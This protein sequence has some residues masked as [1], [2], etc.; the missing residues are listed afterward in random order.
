MKRHNSSGG[1]ALAAL[2]AGLLVMAVARARRRV[3]LKGRV[4]VVTGGGRG[5]GAAI[6]RELVSRGCRVAICGRDE[7]VI[8][9]AV[10]AL[11][12]EGADVMGVRCDVSDPTAT[13]AFVQS[14]IEEYGTVD[15]LVNNAGQCFV[16]PAVEL[17]PADLHRAMR[18]I[19][20]VNF[21]PTMA[22]VP[23]MRRKRFGRI[24]NI[25]SFAGKV[26]VPHQAAYVAA[27]HAT[28]GW[29]HTL[30]LELSRD[31]IAVTTVTP[32]PLK[33][34]APLHV[35]FGGRVEDEFRWFT[36]ALTSP[37]S[38]SS[39]ERTARTVVDALEHGDVD[40]SVTAASWLLSR[41]S[42]AL[43]TVMLRILTLLERRMPEPARAGVTSP[44]RL[45]LEVVAR[46]HDPSVLALAE[47]ARHDEQR[48]LSVPAGESSR[49][50]S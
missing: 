14:V 21:Y 1:L 13:N 49:H 10:Q 18:D 43:P 11:R 22:V 39:A 24:A 7:A 28:T 5:L 20:W 3:P 44:M 46:S 38:A 2:G 29:S 35:H 16:G 15:I 17:Q 23:H 27:K 9:S 30:T 31:G 19:F 25:T 26:P 41:F 32:P 47:R 34:G 8:Q 50:P 6:T 42:G 48:Y 40:R 36:R 37:F 12:A 4:A 45:G 33:D